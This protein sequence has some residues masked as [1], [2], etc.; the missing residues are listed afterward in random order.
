MWIRHSR[1]VRLRRGRILYGGSL[2]G[3]FV[4]SPKVPP[5]APGIRSEGPAL[6]YGARATIVLWARAGGG[7]WW[8]VL[9][10]YLMALAGLLWFVYR[11]G[12]SLGRSNAPTSGPSS[13]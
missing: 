4:V 6:W 3:S 2:P 8:K 5:A 7:M 12:K 10:A 13:S 9:L 1:E 11:F